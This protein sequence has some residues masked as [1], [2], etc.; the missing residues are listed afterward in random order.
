MIMTLIEK[1]KPTKINPLEVLY[2]LLEKDPI[3]VYLFYYL[4]SVEERARRKEVVRLKYFESLDYR[5]LKKGIKHLSKIKL[6]GKW[7]YL[8][9]KTLAKELVSG[10]DLVIAINHTNSLLTPLGLKIWNRL[11][12]RKL[13]EAFDNLSVDLILQPS[14]LRKQIK[15]SLLNLRTKAILKKYFGIRFTTFHDD[16]GNSLT[17]SIET[18]NFY[19]YPLLIE[20]ILMKFQC[21]HCNA[22]REFRLNPKTFKNKREKSQFKVICPCNFTVYYFKLPNNHFYCK[23]LFRAKK[24]IVNEKIP[25][26]VEEPKTHLKN[27]RRKRLKKLGNSLLLNGFLLISIFT[28]VSLL[29]IFIFEIWYG[30]SFDFLLEYYI[31]IETIFLVVTATISTI[32]FL[33]VK[34]IMFYMRTRRIK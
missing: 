1:K 22:I 10:V 3:D 21:N 4:G 20:N 12:M 14:E 6:K 23:K 18:Q 17:I 25:R 5:D 15:E 30:H 8:I 32:S 16:K 9:Q 7:I 27:R 24:K 2:S 19:K 13:W 26:Y 29:I 28:I 31:S 33:I 11:K 34:M